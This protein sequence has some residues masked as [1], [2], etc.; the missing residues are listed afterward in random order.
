M[1]GSIVR[2]EEKPNISP[3]GEGSENPLFQIFFIPLFQMTH[4]ILIIHQDLHTLRLLHDM[5]RINSCVLSLK[6]KSEK[7]KNCASNMKKSTAKGVFVS[8][9]QS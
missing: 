3:T 9:F 8:A 1:I 5:T 6:H 2:I 4:S 7:M